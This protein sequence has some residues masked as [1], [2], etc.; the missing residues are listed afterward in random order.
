MIYIPGYIGIPRCH[1]MSQDNIYQMNSRRRE[2]FTASTID[3]NKMLFI[4][5]LLFY[6]PGCTVLD[7]SDW[8]Q[9]EYVMML[10][11]C[12][13]KMLGMVMGCTKSDSVM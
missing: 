7:N 11:S 13:L 10:S 5:R 4:Q 9:I 6:I 12:S 8:T 1:T 3:G 2:Y